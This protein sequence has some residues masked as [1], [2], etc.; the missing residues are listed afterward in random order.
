MKTFDED[1]LNAFREVIHKYKGEIVAYE[2]ESCPLCGG[3]VN[4]IQA[5]TY[6]EFYQ[7]KCR[8]CG[9]LQEGFTADEA[10]IAFRNACNLV[11]MVRQKR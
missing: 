5:T 6:D 4:L 11:F 7:M 1:F 3:Q 10:I 9:F 2:E 8:Q